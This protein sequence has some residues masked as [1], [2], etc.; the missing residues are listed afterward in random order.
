MKRKTIVKIS[1]ITLKPCAFF[2]IAQYF[3]GVFPLFVKLPEYASNLEFEL[4][5]V[6]GG[7]LNHYHSWF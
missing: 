5:A 4:R 6:K 1:F 2:Q 7:A 3:N